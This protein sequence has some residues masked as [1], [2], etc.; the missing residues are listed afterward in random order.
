MLHL[1]AGYLL[2]CRFTIADD[3][4][5]VAPVNSDFNRQI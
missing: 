4:S 2:Y 3:R 1:P 5:A